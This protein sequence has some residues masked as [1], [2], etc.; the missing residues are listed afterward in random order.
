VQHEV[1]KHRP[2]QMVRVADSA[3]SRWLQNIIVSIIGGLL[4]PV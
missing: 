1:W 4:V 2:E 3:H